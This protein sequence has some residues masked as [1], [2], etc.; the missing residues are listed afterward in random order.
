MTTMVYNAVVKP[1]QDQI[2]GIAN[3]INEVATAVWAKMQLAT[4]LP[5]QALKLIYS[6]GHGFSNI[7]GAVTDASGAVWTA[8]KLDYMIQPLVS[9]AT[10]LGTGISKFY[11][12]VQG[13][14]GAVWDAL[15]LDTM[16]TRALD[17][18]KGM[19]DNIYKSITG[20]LEGIKNTAGGIGKTVM[21]TLFPSAPPGTHQEEE[22]QRQQHTHN[23]PKSRVQQD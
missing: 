2:N 21:D 4:V 8:L 7:A 5:T 11:T 15:Q 12:F 1:I 10:K 13:A 19:A 14:A 9:L 23:N 3:G 20:G 16:L 6:L 17:L 22:Q 18:G